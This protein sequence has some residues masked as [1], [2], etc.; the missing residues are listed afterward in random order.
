MSWLRS[1]HPP[2][3]EEVVEFVSADSQSVVPV[4]TLELV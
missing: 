3:L 4:L 1:R 2:L